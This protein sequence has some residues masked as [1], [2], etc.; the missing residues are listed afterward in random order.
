LPTG[1]ANI[2]AGT[3]R[4]KIICKASK[5]P[6]VEDTRRLD[7]RCPGVI[8]REDGSRTRTGNAVLNLNITRKLALKRLRALKVEKKRYAA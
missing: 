2:S 5:T 8:F 1:S 7:A 3:G 4:L 6:G